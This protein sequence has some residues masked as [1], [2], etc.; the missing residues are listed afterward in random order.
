[1]VTRELS[2]RTK[3]NQNPEE[4]K[5]VKEVNCKGLK[6]T[7]LQR[8]CYKEACPAE[9]VPSPWGK[10]KEVFDITF[11]F[12]STALAFLLYTCNYWYIKRCKSRRVI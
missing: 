3:V 11:T 8:A 7:A 6:P 1:M 5:T 9:W 10:V 12:V 2:C 4:Y